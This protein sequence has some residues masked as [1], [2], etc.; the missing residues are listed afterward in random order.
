MSDDFPFITPQLSFGSHY[1]PV[2]YNLRGGEIGVAKSCPFNAWGRDKATPMPRGA[3]DKL[4]PSLFLVGP[5]PRDMKCLPYD[6]ATALAGFTGLVTDTAEC[7]ASS[8]ISFSNLSP[9]W[10]G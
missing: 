8:R 10:T 6:E 7:I 4:L 3:Q 1:F 5:A 2:A 9:G